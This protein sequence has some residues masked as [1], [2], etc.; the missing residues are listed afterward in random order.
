MDLTRP[1]HL[2]FEPPDRQRFPSLDLEAVR[3][4]ILKP[5]GVE[6]AVAVIYQH[7]CF[8]HGLSNLP[9]LN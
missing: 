1:L 5:V 8:N 9:E 2:D 4:I 3:T 6:Q 7:L